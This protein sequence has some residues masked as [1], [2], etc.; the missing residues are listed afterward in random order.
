MKRT[1]CNSD[2][3]R[4]RILP[5]GL[6]VFCA[7]AST[8]VC[9]PP[10]CAQKGASGGMLIGLVTDS[11]GAMISN[12]HVTAQITGASVTMST[13]TDGSGRFSLENLPPG[14]YKMRTRAAGFRVVEIAT[15][16]LQNRGFKA[17]KNC[18]AR[19]RQPGKR[20]GGRRA[21]RR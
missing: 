2:S 14:R 10:V 8:L 15:E 13:V 20:H 11:T 1:T 7:L 19:K 9:A 5:A 16:R 17:R 18:F 3:L 21:G 4:Q 6:M 12:A